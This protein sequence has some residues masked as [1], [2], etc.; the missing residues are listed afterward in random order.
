MQHLI[1]VSAFL[2]LHASAFTPNTRWVSPVR[3]CRNVQVHASA[4]AVDSERRNSIFE[5]ATT[6]MA[7]F[8][9]SC[10]VEEECDPFTETDCKY[11]EPCPSSESTRELLG[12]VFSVADRGGGIDLIDFQ[13]LDLILSVVQGGIMENGVKVIDRDIDEL[14]EVFIRLASPEGSMNKQQ[15]KSWVAGKRAIDWPEF[16]EEVAT[17]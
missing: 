10:F 2:I 15:I 17:W 5:K 16:M 13:Q 8:I 4:V 9:E 7:D 14:N 3:T 6:V 12:R 11:Y 1:P